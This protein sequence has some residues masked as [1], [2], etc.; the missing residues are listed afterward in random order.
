MDLSS[1]SI[2]VLIFL[3]I[4]F[5]S[6][7][8]E[9]IKG[10]AA[11]RSEEQPPSL[12]EDFELETRTRR[13]RRAEGELSESPSEA[14]REILESLGVPVERQRRSVEPLNE[15]P[16]LPES[17]PESEPMFEARESEPVSFWDSQR[18]KRVDAEAFLS[19]EEKEA[20]ERLESLES[21]QVEVGRRGRATDDSTSSRVRS[22]LQPE[23]LRSAYIL[24]E[25]LDRPRSIREH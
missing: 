18:P 17:E 5:L 22:M 1:E 8:S 16:P 15:P 9:K 4:S 24:K 11:A 19:K 13:P 21:R 3:L 20:L 2:F 25:I 14:M 7:L 10:A 23:S 12:E 6:W